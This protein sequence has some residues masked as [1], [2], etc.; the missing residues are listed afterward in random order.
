M[1]FW[2]TSAIV[3]L[4][5]DE[6]HSDLARALFVDDSDV[7]M[8]WGTPVECAYAIARLRRQG[9][10][11]PAEQAAALGQLDRLRTDSYEVTPGDS[12]RAQALRVVR[13]HALRSGDALQL[14]AALEWAGMPVVGTLVTFDRQLATCAELEGLRVVG[15]E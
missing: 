1:R 3:P 9:V 7:V 5:L 8:W 4:L 12:V 10:L 11:G 13:L 2:D 6:S 15:L 14:A